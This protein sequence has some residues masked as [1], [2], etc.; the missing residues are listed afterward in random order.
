MPWLSWTTGSPT[1]TSDRSRRTFSADVRR[2]RSLLVRDFAV[3]AYSSVSVTSAM[4]SAVSANPLNTGDT[5]SASGAEPASNSAKLSTS[6]G[7]TL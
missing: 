3:A 2:S 5:P 1:L 7:V 4:R 6:S